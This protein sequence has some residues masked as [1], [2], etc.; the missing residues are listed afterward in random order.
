MHNKKKK[1]RK[2]KAWFALT[3]ILFIKYVNNSA[4]N[5]TKLIF[6]T[7]RY[8]I[9]LSHF[10]RQR[11]ARNSSTPTPRPTV[12]IHDVVN[13]HAHTDTHTAS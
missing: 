3:I 5:C 12:D 10:K 13:I 1:E 2:L 4:E 9:N 11:M 8:H 6:R 7:H